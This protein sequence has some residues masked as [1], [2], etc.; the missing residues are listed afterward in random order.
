MKDLRII[1]YIIIA[2]GVIAS[3]AF[4]VTGSVGPG[5]LGYEA[6]GEEESAAAES[7][8]SLSEEGLSESQRAEI[9]ALVRSIIR[10]EFSRDLS[11]R[12]YESMPERPSAILKTQ[13]P[14]REGMVNLN[15]AGKEELM[16]LPGIGKKKAE[17]IINYRESHGL[18]RSVEEIMQISGI[19]EAA[20]GKIRDKIYV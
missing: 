12:T 14:A 18:F 17:D 4:Y 2:A 16:T 11:E 9:T 5:C 7:T 6:L 10:E 3:A 13:E 20:F 15:T 19:K 1:K 8:A